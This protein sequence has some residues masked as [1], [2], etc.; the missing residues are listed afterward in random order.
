MQLDLRL[1]ALPGLIVPWRERIDREEIQ[2]GAR[3]VP[4]LVVPN[5]RARRYILRLTR[6]GFLRLTIPRGGTLAA[7]RQFISGNRSWIERQLQRHEKA[8][9]T[10]RD[11]RVGAEVLFRLNR[12]Q[13]QLAGSKPWT[14][15]FGDQM[16]P[17]RNPE[18][19]LRLEVER[20]LW[21]LA[22]QELPARVTELARQHG[23][24]VNH[25]SVR[26][27]RSRWGSCSRRGTISLNWRLIQAPDFVRDYIILHELAHLRHMNHS[28]A[29]WREVQKLC[30]HFEK[31][32]SWLKQNSGLLG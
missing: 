18:A 29:F 20:F 2:V 15:E 10:P 32:E 27:Q 16:I 5:R 21:D 17:I 3:S 12:L 22:A 6:H 28:A 24:T 19:N 14:L 25:T 8:A 7:A 1:G 31:A 23:F 4:L 13:L 26:N 30:A 9:A 11:W